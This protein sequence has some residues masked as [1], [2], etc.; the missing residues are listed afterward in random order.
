MIRKPREKNISYLEPVIVHHHALHPV[1]PHL[2]LRQVLPRHTVLCPHM[3]REIGRPQ[4]PHTTH[5]TNVALK[6]LLHVVDVV[7]FPVAGLGL[8]SPVTADH[9]TPEGDDMVSV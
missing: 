8:E 9:A 4:E 6:R 7:V 2:L 3:Q 5:V 1:L